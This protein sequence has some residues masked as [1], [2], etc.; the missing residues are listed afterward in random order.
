MQ[1]LDDNDYKF[2]LF[3]TPKQ[4]DC[5]ISRLTQYDAERTK[6]SVAVNHIAKE[7]AEHL[8]DLVN[9][10]LFNG[11][12]KHDV[13]YLYTIDCY[14]SHEHHTT[15]TTESY[16]AENVLDQSLAYVVKRDGKQNRAIGQESKHV[17]QY[18][19]YDT[20]EIGAWHVIFT[21]EFYSKTNVIVKKYNVRFS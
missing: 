20:Y 4:N 21:K 9:R 2:S 11:A 3:G 7:T 5:F 1:K 8:C 19:E 6:T 13:T 16:I 14:D 18:E 15:K 17:G 12:R 10:V